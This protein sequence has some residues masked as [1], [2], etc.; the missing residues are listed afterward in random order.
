MAWGDS[1]MSAGTNCFEVTSV[2]LAP[3]EGGGRGSLEMRLR[4]RSLVAVAWVPR[5]LDWPVRILE[6]PSAILAPACWA[7]S[8]GETGDARRG[9]A[10]IPRAEARLLAMED[11]S[12]AGSRTWVDNL[13]GACN[14]SFAA[15]DSTGVSGGFSPA[16]SGADGG[17]SC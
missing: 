11:V 9:W 15:A 10:G 14:A 8:V 13:G 3:R 1:A 16:G 7:D 2:G 5:S 6:G 4:L 17:C 12:R